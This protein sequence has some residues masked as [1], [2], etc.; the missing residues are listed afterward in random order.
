MK[1]LNFWL[2]LFA[3]CCAGV[4]FH[5]FLYRITL[6]IEPFIYLAF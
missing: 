2:S 6:P 1:R 3:G 4:L 5:Y